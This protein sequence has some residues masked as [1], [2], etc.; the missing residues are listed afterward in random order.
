LF[1]GNIVTIEKHTSK[2]LILENRCIFIVTGI[3]ASGKSTT[4]QLLAE[5]FQ[6]GVHVRGD[7]Y[8]K[9][10]VAGREEMSL[11]PTDEAMRQLKLRYKLAASTADAYFEEGFNVVIQDNII[12]KMLP[13][14]VEMVRN[15]P[16]FVVALCPRPEVAAARDASRHKRA[17]NQWNLSEVDR[18]IRPNT[19]RNC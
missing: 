1:G 16:L 10:V 14:F 18:F 9:M 15:R 8:R 2:E 19:R 4:A 7:I 11:E 12:G 5:R 13:E 17:Y 3:M 6:R